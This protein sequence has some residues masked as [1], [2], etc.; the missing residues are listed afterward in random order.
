MSSDSPSTLITEFEGSV[1]PEETN[2]EEI[3][4]T[5]TRRHSSFADIIQS[6][7]NRSDDILRRYQEKVS[8]N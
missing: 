8:A 6:F 5:D 7:Q 4:D 1:V 3:I 2:M